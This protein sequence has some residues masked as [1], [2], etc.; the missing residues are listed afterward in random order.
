MIPQ[1]AHFG[2]NSGHF[3]PLVAKGLGM[4]V[5]WPC[6]PELLAW[7][8]TELSLG[9]HVAGSAWGLLRTPDTLSQ[10]GNYCTDGGAQGGQCGL[11]L[12]THSTPLSCSPSKS[13]TD[14]IFW[15]Y[16]KKKKQGK[17]ILMICF[18]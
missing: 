14:G 2:G 4:C 8:A 11:L 10:A 3:Y 15:F 1:G 12:P 6:R 17:L 9:N 5:L 16:S 18:N 7:A 13:H